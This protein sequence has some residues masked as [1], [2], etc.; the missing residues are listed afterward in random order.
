[1]TTIDS[2]IPK[3]VLDAALTLHQQKN[4]NLSYDLVN[5]TEPMAIG[6]T[7]LWSHVGDRIE[8]VNLEAR[9]HCTASAVFQK[10]MPF[11][12]T[13]ELFNAAYEL[14]RN[15]TGHPDLA[16]GR[17][18]GLA[19]ESMNL[20]TEAA[21]SIKN[22]EHGSEVFRVLHLIEAS[23][24]HLSKISAKEVIAV[25]DA[26]YESTKRDMAAGLLFNAI[27]Q[28]LK[29][30]PP[31]AWDILNIIRENMSESM[32]SLY[33]TALLALMNTDQRP[34]ALKMTQE[35]SDH[36]NPLIAGTALWTLGRAIQAHSLNASNADECAAIL[37]SKVD[38]SPLSIQQSAIRAIAHAALKNNQLMSEL[39]R[40]AK[41]PSEYTLAVIADF[42]FMNHRDLLTSSPNLDA[43]L[44]ALLKLSPSQDSA[45]ESLDWVLHQ[46]YETPEI[47]PKVLEHLTQWIILHGSTNFNDKATIE[48]FDQTIIQIAN[49]KSG[50]QK[51]ITRWL[52]APEKQLA[53]ACGGLISYLNI[54]EVKSLTFSPEVLSDLPPQ[55]FK[56]LAR[57]L[58]GYVISEKPLLSL[59]L[60]LLDVDN[61]PARSFGWVYSLLIDEIGRDYPHATMEALEARQEVAISPE[62]ELLQQA[63]AILLRRSTANDGLPKLQELRPSI[64]LRRAISLSQARQM[65]QAREAAD[66]NSIARAL[67]TQVPLKAGTGCFSVSNSEVGPTNHLHSFSYSATLPR[68]SITDPAGYAIAGLCYRI[69]KRDEE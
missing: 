9:N 63:H 42:L 58:L 18:L 37:K 2:S 10:A 66:E 45:I 41:E 56:F 69:A 26:Q 21:Q 68:R 24:P 4:V 20:L 8:F 34:L 11:R 62:K 46:L 32:Q 44:N 43:L 36:I 33:S 48:L 29:T 64:R 15:E 67:F 31:L 25:V 14:W 35:D 49:D 47:R 65:E 39:V 16:S 6:N 19:N 1:M 7:S 59:T 13:D 54:R 40:L 60:S 51:I 30:Q 61:A 57:R 27:E 55:D 38:A 28:R 5:V 3:L 53:V 23:L 50:L 52:V 22:K 17:L 12:T